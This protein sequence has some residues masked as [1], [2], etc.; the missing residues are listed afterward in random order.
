MIDRITPRGVDA[1]GKS[2][3]QTQASRE[4]TPGKRT[5]P[6]RIT[7]KVSSEQDSTPAE[8]ALG[9]GFLT[10]PEWIPGISTGRPG[11]N[12]QGPPTLTSDPAA[13]ESPHPAGDGGA[14][15]GEDSR[16]SQSEIS[17]DTQEQNHPLSL[18][19]RYPGGSADAEHVIDWLE[20]KEGER[21]SRGAHVFIPTLILCLKEPICWVVEDGALEPTETELALWWRG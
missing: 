21:W 7:R 4:W 1:G 2:S 10:R 6:G 13:G 16:C 19:L 17:R 18:D 11:R 8:V 12:Y 20:S 14:V 3:R 15:A 5:T 9:V